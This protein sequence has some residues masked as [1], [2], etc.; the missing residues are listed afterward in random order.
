[1]KMIG[2]SLSF[3]NR[4]HGHRTNSWSSHGFFLR[5]PWAEEKDKIS[6]EIDR[7]GDERDERDE[8]AKEGRKEGSNDL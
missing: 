8:R 4:S 3:M 1:M 6:A 2:P 5:I 7:E